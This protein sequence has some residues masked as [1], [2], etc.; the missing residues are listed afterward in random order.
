[1][2]SPSMKQERA[3]KPLIASTMRGNRSMKSVPWR[4]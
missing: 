1:M 3:G 4:V 2:A